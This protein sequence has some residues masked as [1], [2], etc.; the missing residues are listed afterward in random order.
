MVPAVDQA[1]RLLFSLADA[2]Y[3]GTL[4][5][6]LA[7]QNGMRNGRARAILDTFCHAG[8]VIRDRESKKYALGPSLAMLERALLNNTDLASAAAPYLQEL[9]V[10]TGCCVHLGMVSDQTLLGVARRHPPGGGPVS[11][12]VW[13]R[14]PLIWGAH[15]RAYLAALSPDEFER[16]LSRVSVMQA[17]ETGSGTVD[18][19]MLKTEVDE[20][21]RLGYG[22]SSGMTGRDQSAL[23]AVL[24]ISSRGTPGSPRVVGCI[25]AVGSLSPDR[26]HEVG[27]LLIRVAADMSQ[28][29]G[30]LLQVTH[31]LSGELLR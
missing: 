19:E 11:L 9:A 10:C 3:G 13:Y 24:K 18:V 22:K 25:V 6:E 15:G 30:P 4:L 29:L 21:R 26:V 27:C 16:H 12:G 7:E 14:L 5:T 2:A 1:V 31:P 20:C 17:S 8:V 23:S 28:R